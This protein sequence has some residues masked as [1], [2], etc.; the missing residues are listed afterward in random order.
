[1][2]MFDAP[3][4]N[5]EQFVKSIVRSM[6]A[7]ARLGFEF[8]AMSPGSAEIIQPCREELTQ[9]DGYVQAGVLG[10]LAD[11]AGGMAAATLLP[12]GWMNMTTDYTVKIVAPARGQAIVARG[13]VIDS[14]RSTTIAA[15]DVYAIAGAEETLCATALVTM[16]NVKMPTN[17]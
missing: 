11:F 14:R 12:P 5:F 1:M 16:R 6:P 10:T 9:H 15:A 2:T 13:R 17:G 7:A 4:P 8:G 3:N